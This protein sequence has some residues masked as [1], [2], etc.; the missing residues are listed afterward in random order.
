MSLFSND[1]RVAN[2][3][4]PSFNTQVNIGQYGWT[5][6]DHGRFNQLIQYVDQCKQYSDHIEEVVKYVE[7]IAKYIADIEP[8]LKD[9]ENSID[10]VKTYQRI[11]ESDKNTVQGMVREVTALKADFDTKYKN[12][13]TSTVKFDYEISFRPNWSSHGQGYLPAKAIRVGSLV[14]LQGLVAKGIGATTEIGTLPDGAKPSAGVIT[15]CACGGGF[16]VVEISSEGLIVA[17]EGD[18]PNYEAAGWISLENIS[19]YLG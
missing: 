9:V 15:V 7:K 12:F 6:S 18:S 1:V 16:V 4:T 10:T 19:Y 13:V 8:S 3:A 17:R 5:E 2:T 11:V 14:K